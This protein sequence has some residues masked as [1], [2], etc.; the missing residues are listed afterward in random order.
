[1]IQE[2]EELVNMI[3][4][5]FQLLETMD[6]TNDSFPDFRIFLKQLLR[7]KHSKISLPVIEMITLVKRDKPNLYRYLRELGRTD[8]N[9][10]II[11]GTTMPAKDAEQRLA[12]LLDRLEK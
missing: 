9:I 1:M 6:D 5:F 11:V 4:R 12:Q 3:H 2:D 8:L 7:T 10:S